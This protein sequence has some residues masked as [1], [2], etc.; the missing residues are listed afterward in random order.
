MDPEDTAR[1]LGRNVI[2]GGVVFQAISP[3][4]GIPAG[5][6]LAVFALSIV[7]SAM[8]VRGGAE[9]FDDATLWVLGK[10]TALSAL[11]YLGALCVALALF[12]DPELATMLL[13][14]PVAAAI[15]GV[16]AMLGARIGQMLAVAAQ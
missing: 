3:F 10:A 8:R 6:G 15:A 9:P 2:F 12:L 1:A 5:G 13:G 4:L 16:T 7:L 11:L 14:L